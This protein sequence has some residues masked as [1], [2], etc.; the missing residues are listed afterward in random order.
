MKISSRNRLDARNANYGEDQRSKS[1]AITRL[2]NPVSADDEYESATCRNHDQK[3]I[4]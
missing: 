2:G 4:Y 3:G 1:A